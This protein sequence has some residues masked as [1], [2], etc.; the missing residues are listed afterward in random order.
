MIVRKMQ[1]KEEKRKLQICRLLGRHWRYGNIIV[2]Y[3][4]NNDKI[5][6]RSQEEYIINI[7]QREIQLGNMIFHILMY[8]ARIFNY[9]SHDFVIM[10]IYVIKVLD[11]LGDL[12]KFNG[13]FGEAIQEYEK[14]LEL[15][16]AALPDGD[17]YS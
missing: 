2:L 9:L 14:A 3:N 4:V 12:L 13:I 5:M 8:A 11:R 10:Y 1:L 7:S 15:R 16:I 6:R 17:R